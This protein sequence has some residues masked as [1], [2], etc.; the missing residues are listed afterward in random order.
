M[1]SKTKTKKKTTTRTGTSVLRGTGAGPRH[2]I[3]ASPVAKIE[4]GIIHAVVAEGRGVPLMPA[5]RSFLEDRARVPV[6]L[7]R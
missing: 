6:D 3:C 1:P 7:S 4:D 5:Q 2:V